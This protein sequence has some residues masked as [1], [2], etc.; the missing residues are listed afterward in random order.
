MVNQPGSFGNTGGLY[1][2]PGRLGHTQSIK[3]LN[4]PSTLPMQGTQGIQKTDKIK[5]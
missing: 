4:Q 5:Y 1:G 2:E 3:Y